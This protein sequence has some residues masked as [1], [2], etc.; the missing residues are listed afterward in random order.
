[1]DKHIKVLKILDSLV[2]NSDRYL[3][4]CPRAPIE[5]RVPE[6]T[7]S[8]WHALKSDLDTQST[9]LSEIVDEVLLHAGISP[10][11]LPAEMREAF[12]RA[13]VEAARNHEDTYLRVE[14][15]AVTPNPNYDKEKDL[16]ATAM[17][18]YESAYEE[19]LKRVEAFVEARNKERRLSED[20]RDR[21]EYERLRQK[22]RSNPYE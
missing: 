18:S 6:P 5:P 21:I 14:W 17:A 1:M 13:M 20:E 9:R 22:F 4:T 8:K 3:S 11:T 16:Y 7:F 19:Y 12:D 2:V 10:K 15:E